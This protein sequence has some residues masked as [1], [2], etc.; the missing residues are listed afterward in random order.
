LG[1]QTYIHD[2]IIK[3]EHP[4]W[5]RKVSADKLYEINE[6][7]NDVD[8]QLYLSRNAPKYDISVLICTMPSRKSMFDSLLA[9]IQRLIENSSMKIEVLTDDNTEITTG[10]KRTLLLAK[11]RGKYC[12]FIDDDDQITDDYFSVYEPMFVED[13]PD[14]DCATLIGMYYLN[15]TKINPFYH[16]IQYNGWINRKDSFLRYPNHLNL[17]KTEICRKIFFTNVTVGEDIVFSRKLFESKLIQTEYTHEKLQYLY[18]KILD[19]NQNQV[20]PPLIRMNPSTRRRGGMR[21]GGVQIQKK[22]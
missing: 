2:V 7:F 15:G 22:V 3:H 10:T 17:I 19:M 11:A 16:S 4:V 21:M 14:Y 8:Q 6:S 20:Q 1:K 9:T 13:A 18:Y 5:N 12:C